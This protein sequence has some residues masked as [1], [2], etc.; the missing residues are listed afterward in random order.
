MFKS[1][2]VFGIGIRE[3]R[4]QCSDEKYSKIKSISSYKRC[5]S[6]PHHIYLE[7]LSE[8]GLIVFSFLIFFLL[9]C[10]LKSLIFIKNSIK[11][12][13]LY[14]KSEF[15]VFLSFLLVCLTVFFPVKASGSFY[16][17]FYGSFIWYNMSMLVAY[18]QVLK[19]NYN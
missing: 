19:K 6:H 9:A 2:P 17:N 3:F 1:K 8:T 12:N 10:F 7:V 5:S 14:D 18:L 16:S 11:K 15:L 4:N 13:F